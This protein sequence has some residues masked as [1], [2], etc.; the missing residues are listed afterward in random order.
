MHTNPKTCKNGTSAAVTP[1]AT[2]SSAQRTAAMSPP[3]TQTAASVA[4]SSPQKSTSPG[5]SAS[6]GH[7]NLAILMGGIKSVNLNTSSVDGGGQHTGPPPSVN[8]SLYAQLQQFYPQI[9]AMSPQLVQRMVLQFQ[10]RMAATAAANNN[11]QLNAMNAVPNSSNPES[12]PSGHN[13]NLNL[14]VT[15]NMFSN[16]NTAA[17]GANAGRISAP[18]SFQNSANGGNCAAMSALMT[19]NPN[20]AANMKMMHIFRKQQHLMSLQNANNAAGGLSGGV[21][22]GGAS[23]G[24]LPPS[25]NPAIA[26]NAMSGAVPQATQL[27]NSTRTTAALPANSNSG[28]DDAGNT[29]VPVNTGSPANN[30]TDEAMI[31]GAT[32]QQQLCAQQPISQQ[33]QTNQDAQAIANMSAKKISLHRNSLLTRVQAIV[34]AISRAG[35]TEIEKLTLLLNRFTTQIQLNQLDHF[36]K[37]KS[38]IAIQPAEYEATK[39]A[40][41]QL[42]LNAANLRTRIGMQH[43]LGQPETGLTA[44]IPQLESKSNDP[45]I[46]YALA[47][48][49]ASDISASSSF[50]ANAAMAQVSNSIAQCTQQSSAV[51]AHATNMRPTM[52]QSVNP[53]Q[54]RPLFG[55]T[56]AYLGG[57]ATGPVSTLQAFLS[58]TILELPQESMEEQF[59]ALLDDS[60]KPDIDS[61]RGNGAKRKLCDLLA[62][63]N[64]SDTL[65]PRVEEVLYTLPDTFIDHVTQVACEMAKHRH[66]KVA[67]IKDF[68]FPLGKNGIKCTCPVLTQ[69]IY[70]TE[71]SWNLRIPTTI[72]FTGSNTPGLHA[73]TL[74]IHLDHSSSSISIVCPPPKRFATANHISRSIQVKKALRDDQLYLARQHTLEAQRLGEI[75][76]GTKCCDDEK[77]EPGISDVKPEEEEE[78]GAAVGGP[79][80][81]GEQGESDSIK[82]R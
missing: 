18:T 1:L 71:Q 22:A 19:N 34:A 65:D 78:A 33:L 50:P 38:G 57:T 77:E 27:L 74:A 40:V 35:I 8:P 53:Q 43:S 82:L 32:V 68:R 72:P 2:V 37:L 55:G 20:L 17:S 61:D 58:K 41:L 48:V 4:S 23:S 64:A 30:E 11:G 75:A 49:S 45:M 56:E 25:M 70:E 29:P 52:F 26:A 42:K 80:E 59:R 28:V 46:P 10:V 12:G 21:A 54:S 6:T 79:D 14:N 31:E 62:D 76:G 69:L 15:M 7:V 36:L 39:N 5:I 44:Q 67:K 51:A 63:I 73:S 16:L 3:G 47:S 66:S 9:S 60:S 24:A 13:N 81:D